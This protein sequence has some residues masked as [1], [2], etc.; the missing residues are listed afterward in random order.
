MS[1]A[2]PDDAAAARP[3]SPSPPPHPPSPWSKAKAFLLAQHLPLGLAL[4]SLLGYLWPAPG[5]A[6]STTP[7]NTI[8]IVGI[9]FISGLGLSTSEVRAALRAV[10]SYVFG[11]LSILG[12][13]P[14][15][16]LL[17]VKADFGPVEFSRGLALFA[18][19]PTTTT[20]G[21]VMTTEA[22]GNAALS[23]LLAVGT[24]LLGVVTSPF[25]VAAAMADEGAG[26][27]KGADGAGAGAGAGAGG[28]A[29]TVRVDPLDLIWK[30]ALSILLPLLL[31][32]ALQRFKRVVAFVKANKLRLK[33]L[34]SLLLILVPWMSI[35]AAADLLSRASA[36]DIAALAATGTA[37]HL[38]LLVFNWLCCMGLDRLGLRIRL[39]ERKA[40]VVN[41]SQKTLNTAVAVIA[42][43]PGGAGD[44]GL[45]TVPCILAHFA[46]IIIDAFIVAYWKRFT[47]K[48]EA[49]V[50]EAGR[51]AAAPE[52]AAAPPAPAV[53]DWAAPVGSTA[54]RIE[55]PSTSEAWEADGV[56]LRGADQLGGGG[57]DGR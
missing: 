46:Q 39:A 15:L 40:V 5:K 20:S 32:K 14:L 57:G 11:F 1:A 4:F 33:L 44:K 19:M 37:L 21:V 24:N 28:G 35:S 31:G 18:A 52:A 48:E 51:G 56:A 30:L 38:L 22:G 17:V 55:P 25:F 43:L 3:P 41:A 27:G 6:V 7:V 2:G 29:V 53:E 54:P 45:I 50:G 9:F 36:G 26:G 23:V 16:A 49:G 8:S 47:E 42:L 12:I 34:S 10:P 13:S